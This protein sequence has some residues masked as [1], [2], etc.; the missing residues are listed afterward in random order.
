MH[1]KNI[2]ESSEYSKSVLDC[3]GD[4]V[5]ILDLEYRYVFVN[6]ALC[7]QSGIALERW[8]GKTPHELF[9]KEE[10]DI[11]RA[12]AGV[13]FETG[14]QDISEE[15]VTDANGEVRTIETTKTHYTDATGQQYV[16]GVVCDITGHRCAEEALKE[17][18]HRY[19]LLAENAT[20]VIYVLNLDLTYKYVS[21][22]VKQARG[23]SPEELIDQ[24]ISH[25]MTAESLELVT[26][27]IRESL[28]LIK[29]ETVD[30]DRT[31][32]LELEMLCKDGSTVWAETKA[33][34]LRNDNGDPTAIMGIARDITE[35]KRMEEALRRNELQLSQAVDLAD[36]VYW[37]F[38]PAENA[39]I[40][41]DPF[42]AFYGTTA[43]REGGYR[44]SREEYRERF[45]HPD[46]RLS[47]SHDVQYNLTRHEAESPPDIEH[48]IIR[49]DGKVRHI[50]VRA[51]VVKDD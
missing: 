4:P 49:R 20:D 33:S 8:L 7:K 46:D 13:V 24:P 5:F 27:A 28:D 9:P 30:P 41:N 1:I 39:L 34:F 26:R 35:R 32:V 42:Y 44:M 48:R 25:S 12:H 40:F 15:Q 11:F 6:K 14:E 37:E 18:E 31:T 22:S 2:T 38:D 50:V 19:R 16:I 29:D 21:P 23:F 10:A 51:R 3:I 45:V 43:A 17:S 47:Q 36:I